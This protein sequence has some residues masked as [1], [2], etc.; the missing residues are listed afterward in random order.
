[1]PAGSLQEDFWR[2]FYT[3]SFRIANKNGGKEARKVQK[4]LQIRGLVY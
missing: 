4:V 3:D 1:M 2:G